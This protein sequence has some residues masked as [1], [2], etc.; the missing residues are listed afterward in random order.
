MPTRRKQPSPTPDDDALLKKVRLLSVIPADIRA[1]LIRAGTFK[2]LRKGTVVWRRGEQARSVYIILAGRIGL[3]DTE[4]AEGSAV[5]DLFSAGSIAGGGYPLIDPPHVY[6]F[7]GKALDELR[8]M[9]I[10]IPVYRRYVRENHAL[11]MGTAQHLLGGW[12]RLVSQMRDL[13]QLSADQRLG[14]YLLA[15]TDRKSGAATVQLADDQLLIASLLGVTRESLS[16]SFAHLRARGV[17]KR[18]RLVVLGDI[19]SLRQ[20]CG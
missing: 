3:F 12:Q 14:R 8:L 13:K 19:K 9:M 16:R 10:P 15:L 6:L 18:G 5:V 2:S 17:A 7:S 20:F 4:I 11:L 1:A